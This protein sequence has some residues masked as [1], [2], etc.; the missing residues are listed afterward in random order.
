V[1]F[2]VAAGQYEKLRAVRDGVA[3]LDLPRA[4]ELGE[5]AIGSDEE[6]PIRL[7]RYDVARRTED[8]FWRIVRILGHFHVSARI[9]SACGLDLDAASTLHT[10][11]HEHP[12]NN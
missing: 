2:P 9:E 11:C 5:A 6:Q 12:A 1:P 10:G 7:V 3:W 4:G 8:G